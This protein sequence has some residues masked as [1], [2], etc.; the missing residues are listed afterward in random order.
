MNQ[1]DGV[2]ERILSRVVVRA[3]TDC[4]VWIGST[5]RGY[6]TIHHERRTKY[7]HRLTY[8]I[9][10]EPLPADSKT[11]T[12]DHECE[13]SICVNPHHVQVVNRGKNSRMGGGSEAY[14][15]KKK[16]ET[17]CKNGHEYTSESTSVLVNKRNDRPYRRCLICNREAWARWVG[18]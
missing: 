13:V 2:R 17:R 8:E 1:I 12:L 18:K 9:W 10:R 4:W 5:S 6:G 15:R 14:A 7:V 16:K 11:W 3:D